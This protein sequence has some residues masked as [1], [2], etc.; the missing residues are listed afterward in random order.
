MPLGRAPPRAPALPPAAR[1]SAHQRAAR[2][3]AGAQGGQGQRARARGARPC[4]DTAKNTQAARAARRARCR[5]PPRPRP[6]PAHSFTLLDPAAAR[7]RPSTGAPPP[8]GPT[9]RALPAHSLCTARPPACT[10]LRIA[11][12]RMG[13]APGRRWP[14]ARAPARAGRSQGGACTVT[15]LCLTVW[16]SPGHPLLPCVCQPPPAPRQPSRSAAQRAAAPHFCR[17]ASRAR[18]LRARRAPRASPARPP[19]PAPKASPGARRRGARRRAAA[20]V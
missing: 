9:A 8:S 4:P 14:P 18:N 20:R 19:P 17:P 3:A 13:Q 2:H 6:H 16:A 12:P 1:S 11:L 7:L 15:C 10:C 5:A